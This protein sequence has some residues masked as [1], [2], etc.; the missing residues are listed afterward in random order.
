[1]ARILIVDDETDLRGM[2]KM[3]FESNGYEV[4]E[5]SNGNEA[6]ELYRSSPVD[7]IIMDVFMPE[8]EGIETI[9]ELTSEFPDVNVIAISGGGKVGT[10]D[11]L[12]SALEFGAK[13]VFTK[14]VTADRLLRAVEQILK[15]SRAVPK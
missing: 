5:A 11:C 8:K 6:I 12:D 3:L 9:L 7:L 1:M 4:I 2:F 14:P 15:N 13:R 10:R